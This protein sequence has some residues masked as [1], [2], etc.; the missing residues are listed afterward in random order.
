MSSK[1]KLKI[2]I[3]FCKIFW[4]GSWDCIKIIKKDS[5]YQIEDS[6]DYK[7]YM[8]LALYNYLPKRKKEVKNDYL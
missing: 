2:F 7:K 8:D 1:N 4:F 3:K 5:Y 6:I